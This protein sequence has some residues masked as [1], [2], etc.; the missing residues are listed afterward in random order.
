METQ[1]ST[2]LTLLKAGY[3]HIPPAMWDVII[4]QG[5]G[6]LTQHTVEFLVATVTRDIAAQVKNKTAQ[7][8]LQTLAKE[9]ATVASKG[10][11]NGWE[12]GDDI[13]PPYFN[14]RFPIPIPFP[15]EAEFKKE[16]HPAPLRLSG[17]EQL[18]LADA[19]I[20]LAG[21]T[22]NEKFSYELIGIAKEIAKGITGTLVKEIDECGTVPRKIPVPRPKLR[23]PELV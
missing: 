1:K 14:H 18:V 2:L 19:L 15:W 9:M 11:V 7:K 12:E 3:L 4:P 10:M 23:T 22:T 20:S 8:N 5:P 16:P 17:T 21:S 6:K 13:C